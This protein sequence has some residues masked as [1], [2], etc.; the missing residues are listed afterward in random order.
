ME[1]QKTYGQI[2]YEAYGDKA[3]WKAF[4][5]QP[6]PTWAEVRQDIKDKWEHAAEAIAA[7]VADREG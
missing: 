1:R 2:G 4:N 5:G 6:M 7:A 3:E